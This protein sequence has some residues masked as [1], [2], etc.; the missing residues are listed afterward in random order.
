MKQQNNIII[1]ELSLYYNWKPATLKSYTLLL[2]KYSTYHGMTLQELIQE[3]EKD[4]ENIIKVNKRKIRKRL[5]DYI[6]HEKQT[7]QDTTI[8]QYILQIQKMYKHYDIDIPRLPPLTAKTKYETF[9]QIPNKEIIKDILLHVNLQMKSIIT[10]L[11]SSGL[12]ISDLCNLKIKD[13]K[14]SINKYTSEVNI[15]NILYELEK[16]DELIIPRWHINSKKTDIPYIT[17]SSDESIRLTIKYLQQRIMKEELTDNDYLFGY[18][19][20]PSLI[21]R[22]A[23]I[24]DN[25]NL[26]RIN[27]KRFLHAHVLRKYFISTLYNSGVDYLCVEFLA[28]HTVPP[29]KATY[30]KANPDYLQKI[31]M[32]HLAMFTFIN[33]LNVVNLDLSTAEKEELEELRLYKEEMDARLEHLEKLI[34]SVLD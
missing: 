18:K 32:E 11:A 2:N 24:N 16:K 9:E 34:K 20:S 21:T 5:L 8:K 19:L 1:K 14:Q 7:N 6:M 27:D 26:G 29:I 22:F 4:E 3:A 17:F 33:E 23:R 28:G 12:R 15:I 31:Y 13:F 30:Y 10:T 25:L